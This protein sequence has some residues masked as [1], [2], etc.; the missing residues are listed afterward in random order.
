M[1]GIISYGGYVP[2]YR[3][4]R[5]TIFGAMGWINPGDSCWPR[6]RRR[7]PTRTKTA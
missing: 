5:M 7:W 6:G 2:R 1:V 3:L 4:N